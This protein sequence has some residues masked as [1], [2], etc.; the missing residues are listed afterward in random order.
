MYNTPAPPAIGC[1]TFNAGNRRTDDNWIAMV[2]PWTKELRVSTGAGGEQTADVAMDASGVF[3]P[4]LSPGGMGKFR[5][6]A[7]M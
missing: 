3:L 1:S 5:T 6:C 2:H 7:N 4:P